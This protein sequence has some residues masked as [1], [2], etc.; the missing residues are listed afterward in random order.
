[1]EAELEKSR[2]EKRELRNK[3][4]DVQQ[5]L[6]NVNH[7]AARTEHVQRENVDSLQA[8]LADAKRHIKLEHERTLRENSQLLSKCAELQRQLDESK[9]VVTAAKSSDVR[10]EKAQRDMAELRSK[11]SSLQV[12]LDEARK[13]LLVSLGE[14][15]IWQ[16]ENTELRRIKSALERDLDEAKRN[17]EIKA[18]TKENPFWAKENAELREKVT[19]TQ[20]QLEVLKKENAALTRAKTAAAGAPSEQGKQ[21]LRESK[22]EV[23]RLKT[24]L[25]ETA[26]ALKTQKAIA[27]DSQNRARKERERGSTFGTQGVEV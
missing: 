10:E 12:E 9:R 18:T 17:A 26:A 25:E 14:D 22:R 2:A 3:L 15:K 20:A 5:L 23:Q 21:E 6:D 8:E 19:Q 4:A 13:A 1:M 11:N 7:T 24:E 16:R 27:E